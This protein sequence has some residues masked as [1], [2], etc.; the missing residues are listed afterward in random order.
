M[1][2]FNFPVEVL[3]I[4]EFLIQ[5]QKDGSHADLKRMARGCKTLPTPYGCEFVKVKV[6]L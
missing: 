1:V 5:I 6:N 2:K 4:V 3:T